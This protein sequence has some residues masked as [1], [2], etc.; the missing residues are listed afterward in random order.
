MIVEKPREEPPFTKRLKVLTY[1]IHSAIGKDRRYDLQ[2]VTELL[3]EERPDVAALQELDCRMFRTSYDDQS[4]QLASALGSNSFFCPTRPIE[5]GAWG[6]AVLSPFPVLHK[7]EYDVSFARREPRFC[8]RV[9]V[10]VAPGAMLHVFN[11]HLGLATRERSFQRRQMLSEAILLSEDLHHPVLLM[12]DF[13]DKPISVV[14]R[15]LR[16]HFKD[17]F[18]AVGKRW[19]PTFRV[20]PLPIRLDHIYTSPDIR[21]LDC[22]VRKDELAR[23]ASDHFPLLANIEVTWQVCDKIG[24]HSKRRA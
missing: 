3:K 17:A 16:E 19:G 13:N 6:L 10:E 9:D 15:G 2:R 4:A 12:G 23:V 11:C 8:Y 7:R 18:N 24:S 22:W 20:G 14:H 5:K 1:N 21:V